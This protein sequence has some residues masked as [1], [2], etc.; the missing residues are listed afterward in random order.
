MN[1]NIRRDLIES[2]L[3]RLDPICYLIPSSSRGCLAFH[4]CN[5]D[6]PD[7]SLSIEDALAHGLDEIRGGRITS[8]HNV[9]VIVGCPHTARAYLR[10]ELRGKFLGRG[11]GVEEVCNN[12]DTVDIAF[13]V[14][15][16]AGLERL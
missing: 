15:H 10:R 8:K 16:L 11:R 14:A 4:E 1:E 2:A 13:Q 3:R 9:T 12:L 5:C 7:T 6:F